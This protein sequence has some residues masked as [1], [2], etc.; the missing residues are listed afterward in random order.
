MIVEGTH[1]VAEPVDAHIHL[2]DTCVSGPIHFPFDSPTSPFKEIWYLDN[3]DLVNL[4]QAELY[5][6]V[7]STP[8][9]GGEIRGQLMEPTGCCVA[10][11]DSNGSPDNAVNVSDL[12]YLVD[13]LFRG[14]P[15]PPCEEEGDANADGGINVSDLTFLVDFLFRGGTSPPAC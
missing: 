10:R 9:P 14:G 5:L 4:M 1:D 13:F 15:I 3:T 8:F 7:H 11:G 2:G 12:T 6:N